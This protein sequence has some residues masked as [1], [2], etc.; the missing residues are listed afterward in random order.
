METIF[1]YPDTNS[2]RAE[3][4]FI[5]RK[6]EGQR[7]AIIGLGGTGSYILDQVAKTP[8][9]EIH[10][11]DGDIF[12]L[13]NAF[14]S[15]GAI[16]VEKLEREGGLMK[17]DYYYETYSRMHAGIITHPVHITSLNISELA[18]FSYVFISVDKNEAR[19]FIIQE[20]LKMAVPF[21]DTGLGVHIHDNSLIGTLRVTVGSPFKYDHLS[22]RIGAGDFDLN[23][24][25][26]NIQIADLNCMNAMLA[27]MRWKKM[28]GFY[29]DLKEEHN[30]LLFINTNKL[31][32]EDFKA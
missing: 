12:Q 9:A 4:D 13:H 6:L 24:Y 17:V 10:L 26:N 7:I 2:S 8:V 1:R 15:P 3:I 22:K 27:I 14:R 28:S 30:N 25:G 32:N 11:F 20:L 19:N 21:I 31:I 5:N 16:E 23:E 18:G 29:Q